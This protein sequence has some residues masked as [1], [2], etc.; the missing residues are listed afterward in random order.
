[1]LDHDRNDEGKING[2]QDQLSLNDGGEIL[3]LSL[4]VISFFVN[5]LRIFLELG[6]W[7]IVQSELWLKIYCYI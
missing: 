5:F 1:L 3:A 6:F 4:E 7:L 2:P